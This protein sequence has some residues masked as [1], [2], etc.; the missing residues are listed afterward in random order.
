[1]QQRASATP[2]ERGSVV[3]AATV[4][5]LALSSGSAPNIATWKACSAGAAAGAATGATYGALTA[6]VDMGVV[7][8]VGAFFGGVGGCVAGAL[9]NAK[10]N[11]SAMCL[12]HEPRGYWHLAHSSPSPMLTYRVSTG[13]S[14]TDGRTRTATWASAV[15]HTSTTGFKAGSVHLGDDISTT[16]STSLRIQ[17]QQSISRSRQLEITGDIP[18]PD[19]GGC[20]LWQ[21]CVEIP[22]SCGT[23]TLCTDNLRVSNDRSSKPCCVPGYERSVDKP[24]GPCIDAGARI[25]STE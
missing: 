16:L 25:C 18:C 5:C 4:M 10:D 14:T 22:D 11:S 9:S 24:H 21:W 2:H 13:L 15:T 1:M 6:A 23:A 20:L 7:S 8:A 3:G 19:L 12:V 17:L